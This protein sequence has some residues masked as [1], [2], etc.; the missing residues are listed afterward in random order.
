MPTRQTLRI[1]KMI[2]HF[3]VQDKRIDKET[4]NS[5]FGRIRPAILKRL[6]SAEKAA[7]DCR[8]FMSTIN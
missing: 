8:V 4:P 3:A 6:M 1:Q 5:F 2:A 7:A